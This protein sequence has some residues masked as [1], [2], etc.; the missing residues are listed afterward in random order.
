MSELK[1]VMGLPATIATA[2]GIVVAST[3]LVSNGQGFGIAGP[4][5]IIAMVA[6]LIINLF[7]AFTFAELSS[8][9]PK[10]GGIANYTT[11]AMGHFAAILAVISGYVLVNI[12]AGSAEAAIPGIVIN[13]VFLPGVAP[14]IISAIF[15][16]ILVWVNIRGVEF[17]GWVQLITTSVMIGSMVILGFIGLT[18]TGTG[19]PLAEP[20]KA[21]NPMGMGVLALTGLA[22]WLFVGIEFV[23]PMAEEIRKPKVYIPVAMIS[24]LAIILVSNLVYGFASIKYVPLDKLAG[25]TAPQVDAASAILGKGGQIWIAIITILASVSTVN[26]LLAA[27]AR[28]LYGMAHAGQLP[29]FF[30]KLHSKYK[31]PWISLIIMGFVFLIPIMIG[32]TTIETIVVYILAAALCWFVTYII[33]HLNVIIL[34]IKYPKAPRSFKTPLYPLPQILGIASMIYMTFNIF[35]DPVMK[36]QIYILAVTFLVITAVLSAVIVKFKV[37]KGLFEVGP[38]EQFTEDTPE[39]PVTIKTGLAID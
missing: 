14:K 4:G 8:M 24:A 17:F 18:G 34:R 19:A 30:G 26:T 22:F 33:A 32:I 12:F 23:T 36:K 27:I 39:T 3:A 28:M 10:A 29:A 13:Q 16:I 11:P 2:V 25:S 35:P 20:V 9:I 7:V 37:K 1:R 6:A 15:L 21:F 5:F 38:L 31:T